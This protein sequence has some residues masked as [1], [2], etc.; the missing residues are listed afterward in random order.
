MKLE[1][2]EAMDAEVFNGLKAQL[3]LCEDA[4]V[5]L[6]ANEWPEAGLMNGAMGWVRGYIWPEGGDPTSKDPTLRAPLCVLVEFD[7][8][9]LKDEQGKPLT[10]FPD[11]YEKRRWVPI[12][13]NTHHS[14]SED[15]V[16]RRQF[17]LTLAWA[18]THWK[19]QGMTL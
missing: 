14:T 4:R 17:P 12:Y 5:L 8:V 2:L 9:S 6:T 7:E 3:E 10:F 11:D 18:F 1:V 13:R 15:G 19:A 16:A